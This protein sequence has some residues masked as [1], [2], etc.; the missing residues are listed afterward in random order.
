[1]FKVGDKIRIHK[2]CLEQFSWVKRNEIYI[3]LKLN[4][5]KTK[6]LLN[7]NNEGKR[8]HYIL[9]DFELVE[10]IYN[11]IQWLDAVQQNFKEGI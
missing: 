6:A 10:R 7:L 5:S 2:N 11:D 8:H 3:I 9:D 4:D 1:M